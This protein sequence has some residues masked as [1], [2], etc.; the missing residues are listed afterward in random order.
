MS[1]RPVAEQGISIDDRLREF[2]FL[3]ETNAVVCMF[4]D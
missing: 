3:V 2:A 1:G 4:V